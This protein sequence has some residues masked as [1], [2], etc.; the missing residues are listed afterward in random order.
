MHELQNMSGNQGLRIFIFSQK[1][2]QDS[3][4]YVFVDFLSLELL[5]LKLRNRSKNSNG[6]ALELLVTCVTT[7]RHAY[8]DISEVAGVVVVL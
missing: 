5:R 1:T 3:S 7:T 2:L 4:A 6:T 8:T